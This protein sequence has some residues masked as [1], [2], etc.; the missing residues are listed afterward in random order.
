MPYAV[1]IIEAAHLP[2]ARAIA[3]SAFD[4]DAD[5]AAREFVPAASTDGSEPATHWWLATKFTDAQYTELK[6]L[7]AAL[8]WARV[9]AYDNCENPLRPVQVLSEMQLTPMVTFP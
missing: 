5:Q 8:T 9:E 2:S 3:E 7:E 1:V 4:V 6:Q